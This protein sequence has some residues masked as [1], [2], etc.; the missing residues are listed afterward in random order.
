MKINLFVIIN[1]NNKG[2]I[3]ICKYFDTIFSVNIFSNSISSLELINKIKKIY[4]IYNVIKY[5]IVEI[6]RVDKSISYYEFKK[7]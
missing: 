3:I 4:A 2:N 6:T 1:E 7:C 5:E